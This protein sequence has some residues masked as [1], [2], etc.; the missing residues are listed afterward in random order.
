MNI[1]SRHIGFDIDCVVADTMEAFIR[2]AR[3]EHSIMVSPDDITEFMVEEC[4][5]IDRMIIDDIFARLLN[6]PQEEGLKPMAGCI[7]VLERLAA[8]APLTFI[9]ARPDIL[10]I[11]AWLKDHLAQET[12]RT[13]R[14]ISSGGHDTKTAHIKAMGLKY[15]IDDRHQTCI[16]LAAE[17]TITPIVF[18]Q[19]WNRGK[20]NLASVDDWQT[21]DRIC[22]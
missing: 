7:P 9:T 18:S 5:D 10:P 22:S 14:L 20:H 21:I 8:K 1:D 3:E 19:P 4:L 11:A 2:I 12:C 15:F 13:I 6:N 17:Q 16:T